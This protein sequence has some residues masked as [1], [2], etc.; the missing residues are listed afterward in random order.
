MAGAG[1]HTKPIKAGQEGIGFLVNQTTRAFRWCIAEVCR[2]Y[3]ISPDSYTVLR[4]VLREIDESPDGLSSAVLSDK[5][6]MPVAQVNHAAQKLAR[7]GWLVVTGEGD[8]ACLRP[9][10]EARKIGPV[11]SESSR[12]MLDQALKDFNPAEIDELSGYLRRVLKN[13]DA[14]L[15]DDEGPL[16]R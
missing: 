10:A 2:Q 13:L 3:N 6:L 8:D 15:G 5:I 11:L 9:T 12:W 14:P 4:H 1:R 16:H 7:D